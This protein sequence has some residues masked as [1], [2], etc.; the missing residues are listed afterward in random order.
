MKKLLIALLLA[1]PFGAFAE[2]VDVIEFT[3]DEGCSMETYLAIKDD[4]NEQWAKEYGYHAEVLSPIQSNNLTSLFWVG[5][6]ANTAVFGAAWD[7]WSKDLADPDSV[8][9]KLVARFDKCSTNIGR[10][11]Y[12]AY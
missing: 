5:R 6:S 7:Q 8:A 1:M 2:H 12:D 9:S 4:F 3:L 10:R 11:A